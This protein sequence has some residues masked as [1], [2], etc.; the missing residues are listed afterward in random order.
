MFKIAR[1]HNIKFILSGMFKRTE[2]IMPRRWAYGH[3]DWNYINSVHRK[4]GLKIKTYLNYQF[5]NWA[6]NLFKRIKYVS[7]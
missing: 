4:F 2:S 1:R 7:L 5:L 3:L 6:H